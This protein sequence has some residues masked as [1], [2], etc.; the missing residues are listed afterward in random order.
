MRDSY[1]P[2]NR[3]HCPSHEMWSYERGSTDEG[4]RSTG[5]LLYVHLSSRKCIRKAGLMLPKRAFFG[6]LKALR[7]SRRTPRAFCEYYVHAQM[8]RAF[9]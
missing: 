1:R 8:R 4:G 3:K 7:I 6:I 5:I 2:T 9:D